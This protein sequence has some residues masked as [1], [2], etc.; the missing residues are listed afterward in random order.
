MSHVLVHHPSIRP[1]VRRIL[2]ISATLTLNSAVLLMALRPLPAPPLARPVPTIV[3]I[4]TLHARPVM[5]P[6]P[7]PMPQVKPPPTPV[8]HHAVTRH[9]VVAPVPLPS[10]VTLPDTL[11]STPTTSTADDATTSPVTDHGPVQATLA[12]L[13]APAPRYP[14]LARRS[15]M[16]GTVVL[17]VLVDAQGRPQEVSV[18]RSSGYPLLDRAARL[19]VMRRWLFAPANV[20][21]RDTAAWALVP[22]RFNLSDR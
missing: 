20:G 16:Q 5:P 6:A 21:G 22:V 12:Y 14:T 18:E 13:K 8:V 3:P 15:G 9:V 19:Q 2:A 10:T 4:L 7:P 1:D 17:R 11:P